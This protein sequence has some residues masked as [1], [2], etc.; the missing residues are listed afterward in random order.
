M[1]VGDAGR[2]HELVIRAASRRGDVD[3][4]VV[5]GY[6]EIRPSAF[7]A[8]R[9]VCLAA[10]SMCSW[11]ESP[12][13]RARLLQELERADLCAVA[14]PLVAAIPAKLGIGITTIIEVVAR[15]VPLLTLDYPHLK[16]YLVHGCNA[17]LVPPPAADASPAQQQEWLTS[18][19]RAGF[20]ALVEPSRR[21]RLQECAEQHAG[22]FTAEAVSRALNATLDAR[23]WRWSEAEGAGQ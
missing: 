20:D 18:R 19:Y 5:G 12:W 2:Q 13:P 15:G 9:A 21:S 4:R 23:S 6:K 10:P 17:H 14:V 11:D 22:N 7:R 3:V 1:S 16:H 8:A